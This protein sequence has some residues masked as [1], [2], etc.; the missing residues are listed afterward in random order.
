MTIINKCKIIASTT[1]YYDQTL[2]VNNMEFKNKLLDNDILLNN[3]TAQSIVLF[4]QTQLKKAQ[5]PSQTAILNMGCE[6]ILSTIREFNVQSICD[7]AKNLDTTSQRYKIE[8]DI[9]QELYYYEGIVQHL[10]KEYYDNQDQ[11]WQQKYDLQI[12]KIYPK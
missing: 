5:M 4:T 6:Y 12:S 1:R 10:F 11:D 8:S 2:I 9:H 3:L 7:S